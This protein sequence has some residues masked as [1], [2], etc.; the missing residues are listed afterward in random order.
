M[1]RP[2]KRDYGTARQLRNAREPWILATSLTCGPAKGIAIYKRRMQ[3]EETFRDAKS[4]RFGL[5]MGHARTGSEHRANVLLLLAML[6]RLFAA[7]YPDARLKPA[8]SG[9]S[10]K[11]LALRAHAALPS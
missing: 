11:A 7:S 4:T 5:S 9:A 10:W 2:T 6:G 1:F 3:I 8:L